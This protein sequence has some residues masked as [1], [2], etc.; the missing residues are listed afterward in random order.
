[1][2]I[3]NETVKVTNEEKQ[4]IKDGG[5]DS[6][7]L[8]PTAQG[9]SG[10]EIRKR[11]AK[12]VTA[13][14]GSVLSLVEEKLAIVADK[15][16]EVDSSLTGKEPANANIQAHIVD[17]NDPH[18][19]QAN[20][21]DGDY[22]GE[23]K[24]VQD[25]IDTLTFEID[26]IVDGDTPITYEP[27]DP[28]VPYVVNANTL[29]GAID[30]LDF[31]L[32][33]HITDLDNPHQVV[34]SQVN[35]TSNDSV[36]TVLDNKSEVGH[37]H[38][39][40]E[41]DGLQN[42]L[43]DKIPLSQKNAFN[44][45][46]TLD[47]QGKIIFSQL[48]NS[49]FGGLKFIGTVSAPNTTIIHGLGDLVE[50]P[51]TT[52][53]IVS[54]TLATEYGF[55]NYEEL[56]TDLFKQIKGSYFVATSSVRFVEQQYGVFQDDGNVIVAFD[57]GVQIDGSGVTVEAGDWLVVTGLGS[58]PDV[59]KFSIV[60]N[61]YQNA[62]TSLNG[63]VTLS[64]I[65]TV[66]SS[67]TGNQV[68]T[69]GILGGLIGN[70][71]NTIAAGVHT[72]LESD[73]TDLDKYTQEQTDNLLDE[74]MELD[75]SN[76]EIDELSFVNKTDET[77]G[78]LFTEGCCIK[79]QGPDGLKIRLGKELLYRNFKND[80]GATITK[81][82]P[83]MF[84]GQ[85]GQ[86]DVTLIKPATVDTNQF[87]NLID[88]PQAFFG[89]ASQD[90]LNEEFGAVTWFGDVENIVVTQNTGSVLYFD[91]VTGGLT[92][93]RP[94]GINP[95][96]IVGIVRRKSVG[97]GDNGIIFV[98]PTVF[99]KLSDLMGIKI[100]DLENED[101][102]IYDASL[103]YF[104]NKR[105][106]S[107][108]LYEESQKMYRLFS[109]TLYQ[110]NNDATDLPDIEKNTVIVAVGDLFDVYG[111]LQKI[112]DGNYLDIENWRYLA[113]SQEEVEFLRF[114]TV[115][116]NIVSGALYFEVGI[117]DYGLN[118]SQGFKT[119]KPNETQNLLVILSVIL[120]V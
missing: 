65:T 78:K 4:N 84:G 74:K 41:V 83:I 77:I 30:Q 106:T 12:S 64:N 63:I 10:Q 52:G 20:Q 13:N 18:D 47:E 60:N 9:F 80:T 62:T 11:L 66:N 53:L 40:S 3:N 75:G 85:L 31:A 92:D 108:E 72:H 113:A 79:F 107:V 90:I 36:Q 7:P 14:T 5:V 94:N 59:L 35:T 23:P 27:Q 55:A 42:A 104:V 29:D 102:I 120:G 96:I 76:S 44:G 33:T 71:A 95:K 32:Y 6:L 61:T 103:G 49:V 1:M 21:V 100:E 116:N 39:I 112:N 58:G 15:F 111:C 46:A 119:W 87:W 57:D 114:Y 54:N 118:I 2:P 109:T 99:A 97:G 73:I 17:L 86:S 26:G 98:K 19:T 37:T 101:S 93:V 69:Q 50:G 43:D 89:L 25:S 105:V 48:P 34:A 8:N 56:T 70:E 117:N 38:P 22:R 88:F 81:G 24:D 51:T 16:D 68:I 110:I 91:P 115:T 45:V 82:T 28:D 67:T